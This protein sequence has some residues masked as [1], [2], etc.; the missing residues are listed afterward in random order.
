MCELRIR[1]KFATFIGF[2]GSLRLHSSDIEII[3]NR[4]YSEANAGSPVD[5]GKLRVFALDDID[6][7]VRP[8]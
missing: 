6:D 4:H 1:N 3:V 5:I 8:V 7:A 2:I